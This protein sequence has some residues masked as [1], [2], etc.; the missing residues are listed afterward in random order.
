MSNRCSICA[1]D[2][3]KYYSPDFAV[4]YPNLTCKSCDAKAVNL[5]G[6]A[7]E[8]FSPEDD[9]DNPLFIDGVK[10]WR[11]YRFGGYV[12]MRDSHD[13]ST[14]DEFYRLHFPSN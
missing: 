12:T 1:A 13:C 10:C 11:R 9:G 4:N 3:S 2:L 5:E 8:H 6:T 14:L 7:P